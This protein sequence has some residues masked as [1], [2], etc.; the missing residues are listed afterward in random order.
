MI[1]DMTQ[2]ARLGSAYL[3]SAAELVDLRLASEAVINLG[4]SS[5]I[6]DL[7]TQRSLTSD[8][9][10][11]IEFGSYRA[12]V[13]IEDEGGKLDINFVA[14]DVLRRFLILSNFDPGHA[15]DIVD[16]LVERRNTK[17]SDQPRL[18]ADRNV[19]GTID[20]LDELLAIDAMSF[21][22]LDSIRPYL[23]V[24]SGKRQVNPW[25][26]AEVVLK[27][28]TG[29]QEGEIERFIEERET[30]RAQGPISF[31]GGGVKLADLSQISIQPGPTFTIRAVLDTS[32][33]EH[34]VQQRLY[35]VS[36]GDPRHYKLLRVSFPRQ[37]EGQIS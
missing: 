11:D 1:A 13:T 20:S 15:K 9:I 12:D 27:S 5:L 16:A 19:G 18:R 35:W 10:H 25:T 34:F 30:L 23:T 29:A 17:V 37:Q 6:T 24:Y 8:E 31:A 3:N 14:P 28:L 7:K 4:V 33:G 36:V 32:D 2:R 26:A 21:E 22:D